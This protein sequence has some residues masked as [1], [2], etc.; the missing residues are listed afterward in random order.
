ME[1]CYDFKL[2]YTVN[3]IYKVT[4]HPGIF[5]IVYTYLKFQHTR[6]DFE[7]YTFA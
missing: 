6:F 4:F 7:G 3:K 2:V 1:V 5:K